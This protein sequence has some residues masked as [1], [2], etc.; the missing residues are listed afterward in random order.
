VA[1]VEVVATLVEDM[2]VAAEQEVSVP[3]PIQ[4][5]ITSL[6]PL[7]WDQA[8]QERASLLTLP[9][10]HPEATPQ[11]LASV[12]QVEVV[13]A[14]GLGAKI[15]QDSPEGREVVHKMVTVQQESQ[16]AL[17]MLVV[18]HPPREIPA[19]VSQVLGDIMVVAAP[20]QLPHLE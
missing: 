9:P 13:V 1:V 17:V 6:I 7:P 20:M 19:A 12:P 11:L 8:A 14:V 2:A 15:L 10:V 3:D 16:A 4:W 5:H 18:T